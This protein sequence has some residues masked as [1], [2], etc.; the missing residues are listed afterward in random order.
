[1]PVGLGNT[2]ILNQTTDLARKSYAALI[3]RLMPN[4]SA[5]LFGMTSM[6][7]TKTALQFEHGYFSKTMLFPSLTVTAA[8]QTGADTTFTIV[9]NSNLMPGMMFRNDVSGENI[10]I[11]TVA[12]TTSVTV[13]RAVGTV[14]AVAWAANQTAS[15]VGNAFEESSIRPAPQY[16]VPA[17]TTNYTQIFR[18]SWGISATVESTQTI[19]GSGN[20]A[21]NKNDA[22]MFHAVDIEKALFFGQKF[23]GT[24]NGQPFHT[25]DGLVN[26]IQTDASGNITTLGATTNFTQIEAAVDP[27]FEIATDPKVANER[28]MFV[29]GT[30][31]KVLNAIGRL[32]GTYFLTADTNTYGLRYETFRLSR[33]TF[34]VIEHPLFNSNPTWKKMGVVVDLTSFN[35]AYLGDRNTKYQE[36]GTDG[37][38]VDSGIDAIGGTFTTECTTEITNPSAS[39]VLYNF[40]NGAV[41]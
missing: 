14:A 5:P 7:P 6:L 17:R 22:A 15:M 26:R 37:T 2:T 11:N 23:L 3:T 13:T 8:G 1:M 9:A 30:A 40:T 16:I 36:Y 41:G 20:V 34:N 12:S 19:A 18:N 32:N 27:V 24:R 38:P 25:M 29:G 21:E 10:V 28:V 31:R 39:A 35:I 4:G 33:G